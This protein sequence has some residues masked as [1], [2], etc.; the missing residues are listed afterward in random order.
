MI[1]M[2]SLLARFERQCTAPR[3]GRRAMSLDP[4]VKALMERMQA[5]NLPS[6]P[7][8]TPAELRESVRQRSALLPKEDVAS[9]RDHRVSVADGAIT[10]RVFTP[11]GPA[12]LP[13]LV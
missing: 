8:A 4:Q 1:D 12:P 9:V 7:T 10:V 13:A 6:A 2:A 5:L 3:A 11:R